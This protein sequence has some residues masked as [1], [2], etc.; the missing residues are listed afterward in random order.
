VETKAWHR[1][2]SQQENTGGNGAM[3][4]ILKII[5]SLTWLTSYLF[6]QE[7]GVKR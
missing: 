3:I 7:D 1:A 4:A 5:A 2:A 6:S